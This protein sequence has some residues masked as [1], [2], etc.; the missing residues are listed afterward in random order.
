MSVVYNFKT[1]KAITR[2]K[3]G[4]IQSIIPIYEIEGKVLIQAE[5]LIKELK[6]I[7][8]KFPY[9]KFNVEMNGIP[10]DDFNEIKEDLNYNNSNFT[11]H[12]KKIFYG[13]TPNCILI[14]NQ[15]F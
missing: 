13:V 10:E 5:N 4:K 2:N 14:L 12:G 11:D 15:I 6:E 7:A 1:Q 8:V 3:L 9:I